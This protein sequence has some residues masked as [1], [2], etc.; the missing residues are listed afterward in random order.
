M[1]D[2]ILS[3]RVT[4]AFPLSI[5]TSYAFESLFES[6]DPT[7]DETRVK[8]N[9]VDINQYSEFWI[10]IYTLIR[11]AHNALKS[12]LQAHITLKGM[13]DTIKSEIDFIVSL[14][15]KEGNDVVKPVFYVCSYSDL[16]NKNKNPYSLLRT[17]NTDKQLVFKTL[18]ND[19]INELIAHY[20]NK[21]TIKIFNSSLNPET[22]Q[23]TLILTHV[24]Q[25]LTSYRRFAKLDLLESHTGVL[26]DKYLFYTKYTKGKDLQQIPFLEGFLK[27]FGD[28][29]HHKSYPPKDLDKIIQIAKQK[30]W[31]QATSRD[32]V[33]FDIDLYLKD[34]Y[35]KE[36]IKSVM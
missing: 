15:K 9:K 19:T 23:K 33:L 11:N 32:K 12:D 36:V 5:G 2:N 21:D 13:F 30:N 22:R 31:S 10:N 25:D 17:D 14:L 7:Y 26:K 6:K 8:P 27:I 28:N 16:T 1:F 4:S 29:E 34:P 3:Q 35:L 18:V 20:K 24:A